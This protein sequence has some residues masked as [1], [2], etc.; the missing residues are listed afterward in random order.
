MRDSAV[1]V[2]LY[3]QYFRSVGND[4]FILLFAKWKSPK[5]I[6]VI[7]GA[8]D[9]VVKTSSCRRQLSGPRLSK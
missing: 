9:D 7:V 8:I 3:E 4:H 1:Y 2:V 6:Y 5:S